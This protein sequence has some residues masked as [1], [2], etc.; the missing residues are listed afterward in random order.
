MVAARSK[1]S[2]I[3]SAVRTNARRGVSFTFKKAGA[4]PRGEM[5]FLAEQ[6]KDKR[7]LDINAANQ[8]QLATP[9]RAPHY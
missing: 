6:E 8:W 3:A 5:R 9:S 4:E 2:R 7:N 1:K